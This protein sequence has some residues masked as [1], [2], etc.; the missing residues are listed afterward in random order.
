MSFAFLCDRI[1]MLFLLLFQLSF[2][3]CRYSRRRTALL[4]AAV[5]LVT[6]PLE[7]W[8]SS[9][10][11]EQPMRVAITVAEIIIVQGA[12]M[13]FSRYRDFRA[14]FVGLSSA[15]YVLVGNMLGAMVFNATGRLLPALG[16]QTV[17]HIV[18]LAVLYRYCRQ[19]FLAEVGRSRYWG[20]FCLVPALLYGIVYSLSV[21]PQS[22]YAQ[23][24][25]ALAIIQVLLLMVVS[26]IMVFRTIAR[27]RRDADTRRNEELLTASVRAMKR[28]MEANQQNQ[29]QLSILKHDMRHDN[30]VLLAYLEAGET[31]KV[32][33]RLLEMNEDLAHIV[34]A[35]YCE[36]L[37]VNSVLH[38]SA[39]LAAQNDVT[40]RCKA[41]L[42]KDL[43]L[44]EL[45]LAAVISNLTENA[46][47]A[48]ARLPAGQERYVNVKICPV[49][50]QLLIAVTN[51]YAGVLEL[52]P[53]TGLPR[54][55]KG[56]GHGYGLQ[57]VRFFAERSNAM[58]DCDTEDGVFSV[59]ML[60][61][62]P[63]KVEEKI[64]KGED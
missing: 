55:A 60:I 38:T 5:W 36:N 27:M 30:S 37:A 29:L 61:P 21:W 34:T 43:P 46:V 57:S 45:E 58:F 59:R 26:Y 12:A 14:L 42:K 15:A 17:C 19:D 10:P 64:P 3:S 4:A 28:E 16:L 6:A 13:L 40:F 39:A 35:R 9:M 23:P 62:L 33:T 48:A 63:P 18:V 56:V 54:S 20:Y 1:S 7:Y 44:P 22:I 25:N 41:L 2:L 47:Q 8:Q 49:K 51:P 31:D 53:E 50:Q 24:S 11:P 32:K 52:S